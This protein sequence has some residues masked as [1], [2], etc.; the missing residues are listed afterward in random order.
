LE[1]IRVVIIEEAEKLTA[2]QW[3]VIEPIARQDGSII[4]LIFNPD[5]VTD[6]VYS[7]FVI[8][9]PENAFVLKANYHHNIFLPDKMRRTIE[10]AKR[11]D[12]E[13]YRHV[14][15]GEPNV[16][17]SV[18]VIKKDWVDAC[19]GA[20]EVLDFSA[21][22]RFQ[23]KCAGFDV[24]DAGGDR[25]TWVLNDRG[26]I[27]ECVSWKAKEGDL[28]LSA[29]SA[30]DMCVESGTERMVYDSVGVGA[31]VGGFLVKTM[32]E[33]R[34]HLYA[35]KFIAGS[36]SFKRPRSYVELYANVRNED[37]FSNAK[38]QAWHDVGVRMRHTRNAVN[39]IEE[40]DPAKIISL[41]ERLKNLYDLGVELCVPERR[42]DAAG[43]FKIESKIDL[44]K[45]G[46]RSTDLADAL[47]MSVWGG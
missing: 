39:G 22:A 42:E 21:A 33:C 32:K 14:Y 30:H 46:I 40:A 47:V 7:N 4:V 35:Q 37:F 43:K 10:T 13:L 24:A 38:A 27:R 20:H 45:R 29:R 18:S 12:P 28:P 34:T 17:D 1:K 11:V 36:R 8:G 3:S 6:F 44:A 15:L 31:G 9:R 23:K 41:D 16:S 26:I 25:C 2:E 19:V 5:K